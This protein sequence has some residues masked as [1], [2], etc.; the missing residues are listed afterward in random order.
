M[1]I[2]LVLNCYVKYIKF[3]FKLS[4]FNNSEVE[5]SKLIEDKFRFFSRILINVTLK[6]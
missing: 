4:Y 3:Y 6:N 2:L 1:L 5:A